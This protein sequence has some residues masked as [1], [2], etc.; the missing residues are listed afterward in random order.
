MLKYDNSKW[1]A[2]SDTE[3]VMTSKATESGDCVVIIL[4]LGANTT[5]NA[6]S[7]RYRKPGLFY[8]P[9]YIFFIAVLSLFFFSGNIKC[10]N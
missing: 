8:H 6:F 2:F 10:H 7:L 4:I 3:I 9:I 1:P 5:I